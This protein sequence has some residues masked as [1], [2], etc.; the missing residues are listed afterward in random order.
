[1]NSTTMIVCE[2]PT[3]PPTF[4]VKDEEKK[5]APESVQLGASSV[6]FATTSI[7][8]GYNTEPSACQIAVAPTLEEI[9]IEIAVAAR[10]RIETALCD[11][12]ET[13]ARLERERSAR[14]AALK[15][16]QERASKTQSELDGMEGERAAMEHRAKTFLTTNALKAAMES[17]HLAFNVRQLEL[18]DALA[19]ANADVHGIQ[20]E[21]QAAAV[22]DALELQLT[23]QHL[24]QLEA[25]APEVAKAVHLAASAEENISA[26]HQAAKDG[27]LYDADVL[28]EKA[29]AGNADP[30]KIA[31]VERM[32]SD[33]KREKTAHDLVA[34]M[35]ANPDKPGAVRRIR[36][37]IEEAEKAG[38][39]DQVA[40]VAN[41]ALEAARAAANVRFA[42]ARPIAKHLADDGF[43]PVIGDGRIEAWKKISRNGHGMAWTLDRVMT[44]RGRSWETETPRVPITRQELPTRVQHSRW[45]KHPTVETAAPTT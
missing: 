32:L 33:G 4:V 14:D 39:A 5:N 16:A 31:A 41:R 25:A 21:I 28:L 13:R 7:N 11:L 6:A 19:T 35:N 10:K 34:R 36:K 24:E 12:N 15:A 8:T 44:L 40:P 18:E 37:L 29:R 9:E 3:P 30:T 17:I 45:F 27:L 1:M 23:E 2:M 38:V 22:T 26:A 43:V 42:Q 20:T